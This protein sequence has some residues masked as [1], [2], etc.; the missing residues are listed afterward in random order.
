M[1]FCIIN[2]LLFQAYRNIIL[3]ASL[4]ALFPVSHSCL[5]GALLCFPRLSAC[6]FSYGCMDYGFLLVCFANRQISLYLF[7]L[8]LLELI[9]S[10][11]IISYGERK[12]FHSV[13]PFTAAEE[14]SGIH[15]FVRYQIFHS[16]SF[17]DLYLF[18]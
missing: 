8:L 11:N 15:F 3:S 18:Y 17:L 7:L 1:Q 9:V 2:P 13:L 14:K 16:G 5:V 10:N 4:A 6:T 12:L